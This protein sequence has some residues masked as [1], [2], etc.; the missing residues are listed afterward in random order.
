MSTQPSRKRESTEEIP[1]VGR[2][3][4]VYLTLPVLIWLV[5]WHQ[6]WVG[7]PVALILC[8][9]LWQPLSGSWRVA[10]GPMGVVLLLVAASWVMMT[11][12][13][14]I[15]DVHNPEWHK[16]R[17]IFLDLS[18]FNWPVYLPH[19]TPDL[20]AYVSEDPGQPGSL[21]RYYLGYY[22]VPGL[23]GKWFGQ[24]A[25]NVAV[26]LWTWAGA[27]LV[28]VMVA[29]GFAG[30]KAL[31]AAVVFIVFS[32]MDIVTVSLLEGWDWLVLR[33]SLD[34]WPQVW[35]GRNLLERNVHEDVKVLFHSHMYGMMWVPQHF[36]PGA[37]YALLLFQLRGHGRFLAVSGVA[38][39]SALFWSPFVAVGLLPLAAVLVVSKRIR[40]FLSWQNLLV[41]LPVVFLLM[42]YLT[43]STQ[44]V[45]SSW[46]WDLYNW[47]TIGRI[48]PVVYL[49]E[50]LLLA[51]L[52]TLLRPR[53]W[54][55]PIFI[56]SL[57]T[58]LLLPLYY[59]G[60]H[61]DLVL[62]GLVPALAL[63]CCFTSESILDGRWG[64][65]Q[66]GRTS[67][68]I[69]FSGLAVAVLGIGAVSPLFELARANNERNSGVA[70]Y[71]DMAPHRSILQ[72]PWVSPAVHYQYI[73]QQMPGWYRR[74][75]RAAS[76][77][78]VGPV[79]R[80]ETLISS[81]YTVY[82]DGRRLV[83]VNDTCGSAEADTRFFLQV[84]PAYAGTLPPGR[85]H[86]SYDFAFRGYG[87][88]ID[89][90]CLAVVE[91][92]DFAIGH[93]KTGQLN[94]ERTGHSW[95]RHYYSAAYRNRLLAEA[96]APV[97]RST[98]DVYLHLENTESGQGQYGLRRLLFSKDG[99]SQ[100]DADGQFFVDVVPI[101][102][103]DLPNERMNSGYDALRF[104]FSDFGGKSDGSCFVIFALPDYGIL[105][106][107]TGQLSATGEKVW[108]GRYAFLD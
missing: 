2:L 102:I 19:W 64:S 26:P 62:R 36:I 77:E 76:N 89:E 38:V 45:P 87:W 97:V 47:R 105:E 40:P 41:S 20:A 15:F 22:I 31:T 18:R 43:A 6:W 78:A 32:G 83:Y 84:V 55:E 25:L 1:V 80:G 29:R 16:H 59:F 73:A 9:A 108:E 107:R 30:W 21:L 10:V 11:A 106:I 75:L 51:V 91:M 79:A 50:F 58:L 61:N 3:A 88:R 52:I 82:R 63:L 56:A 24:G 42:A 67:R 48:M 66:A 95:L 104:A 35:F 12:A 71:A 37:L 68:R 101:D 34:G 92:P 96:G 54:R 74:M 65:G 28:L 17:A 100:S 90:T 93:V 99:C 33:T 85:S 14:G 94:A 8:L 49:T 5:G 98:Y 53:I 81:T 23:L 72:I 103:R 57:A 4:I 60:L 13:G 70:R 27:A 7:I 86:F 46:L 44:E 69:V 39:G